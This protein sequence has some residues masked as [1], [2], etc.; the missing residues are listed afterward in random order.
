MGAKIF[1]EHI[2]IIV[3]MWLYYMNIRSLLWKILFFISLEP[4]T[5]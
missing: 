1:E 2:D 5:A 4:E 3:K